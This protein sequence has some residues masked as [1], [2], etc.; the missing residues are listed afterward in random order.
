MIITMYFMATMPNHD[1]SGHFLN[2]TAN[3]STDAPRKFSTKKGNIM[4]MN[5]LS[6]ENLLMFLLAAAVQVNLIYQFDF[7]GG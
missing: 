3:G 2:L 5:G 4:I 1:H 6:L 7:Y